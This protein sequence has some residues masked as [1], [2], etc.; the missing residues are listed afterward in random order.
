MFLNINSAVIRALKW[1]PYIP[2]DKHF[3]GREFCK[4]ISVRSPYILYACIGLARFGLNGVPAGSGFWVPTEAD[5]RT[6]V[7]C[8]R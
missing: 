7:S 8:V 2:G 1:I 3:R 4:N 5:K 6:L